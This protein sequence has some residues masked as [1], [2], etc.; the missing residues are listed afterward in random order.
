MA[1]PEAFWEFSLRTYGTA[2]VAPA[3]LAL[4]DDHGLDVNLLLYC[5]WTGQLGIRLDTAALERALAFSRPWAEHVVEP[6]RAARRWMKNDGCT[7]AQIPTDSCRELRE[8][9]KAI[10]LRSEQFQQRVLESMANDAESQQLTSD[11]RL[12][13][14]SANLRLYLATLGV[15]AHAGMLD[16][17][18][19]VVAAGAGA[20]A[21][22][23]ARLQLTSADDDV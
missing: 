12:A 21:T 5:C 11:T 23:V 3:C 14:S 4:Q 13:M 16:H 22:A 20:T 7:Q 15:Q 17:L 8:T 9:I 18:V 2:G 6:L 19:A 10:E 1:L